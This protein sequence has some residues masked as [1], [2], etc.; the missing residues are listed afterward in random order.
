M[1]VLIHGC[2]PL[3]SNQSA[4]YGTGVG[5]HRIADDEKVSWD[6]QNSLIGV[7]STLHLMHPN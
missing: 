6:Q 2:W 7:H 4:S 1:A 3:L 5:D